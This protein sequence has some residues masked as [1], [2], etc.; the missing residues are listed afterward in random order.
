MTNEYESQSYGLSDVAPRPIIKKHVDVFANSLNKIDEKSK[1]ALKQRS[2]IQAALS[3][4]E[5]DSSE[6]EWK[7]EYARNIQNQIDDMARGG[8]YSAALNTAIKLSGDA[9]SAPEL[10]GRQRAHKDREE[11]WKLIQN[12]ADISADTKHAWDISNKYHYEDTLDAEGHIVG[13][14]K[15][16]ADWNPVTDVNDVERISKYVSLMA[17]EQWVRGRD[18]RGEVKNADG[19]GKSWGSGSDRQYTRLTKARIYAQLKNALKTDEGWLNSLNQRQH[20]NSILKQEAEAKLANVTDPIQRA[21]LEAKINHY[22]EYLTDENGINASPY[23]VMKKLNKSIIDNFAYN[24]TSVKTS[25]M[26]G[27]DDYTGGNGYGHGNGQIDSTNG[28][29]NGSTGKGPVV[30]GT[31]NYNGSQKVVDDVTTD[32]IKTFNGNKYTPHSNY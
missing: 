6:D 21:D 7:A 18:S 23:E 15:W 13:G 22:K 30:S 8:D 16:A 3:Q 28:G 25:Y 5:L 19:T 32:L 29:F 17:N 14:T 12:R 1:E 4:V 10:L 26:S 9:I 24:H 20:V 27:V 2:A 31:T 11:Q